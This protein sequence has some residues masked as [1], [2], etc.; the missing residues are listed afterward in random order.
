MVCERNFVTC[1]ERELSLLAYLT[2]KRV[3]NETD[4]RGPSL[5]KFRRTRNYY[6]ILGYGP[7]DVR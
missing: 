5:Y 7:D 1:S 4:D 3:T 2:L 6:D